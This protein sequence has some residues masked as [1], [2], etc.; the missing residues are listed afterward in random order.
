[1]TLRSRIVL[2]LFG[3][4]LATSPV[5]AGEPT[6]AP[7]PDTQTGKVSQPAQP[8]KLAKV[9]KVHRIKVAPTKVQKAPAPTPEKT[10]GE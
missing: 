4:T 3:A 10:K 8:T 2:G 9:S 6:P 1:M 5:L 7:K